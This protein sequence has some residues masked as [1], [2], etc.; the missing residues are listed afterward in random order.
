MA[1][2]QGKYFKSEDVHVFPCSYRGSKDGKT[3]D[4]E[5]RMATEANFVNA[6]TQLK[7][8]YGQDGYWIEEG[9]VA[10]FVIHGYYFEIAR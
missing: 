7:A 1:L 5:A 2:I 3:F 6:G 10:K 4:P 8:S 9:D